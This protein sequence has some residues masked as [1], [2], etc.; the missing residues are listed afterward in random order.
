[1][2]LPCVPQ[3]IRKLLTRSEHG[4][5]HLHMKIKFRGKDST[6]PLN[7]SHVLVRFQSDKNILKKLFRIKKYFHL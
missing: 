6:K 4:K 7:L 2:R 5:T 1:M 3:Q